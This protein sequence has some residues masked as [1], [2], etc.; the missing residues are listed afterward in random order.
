MWGWTVVWEGGFI[1]A[2]RSFKI[3]LMK[4]SNSCQRQKVFKGKNE[5]KCSLR[6]TDFTAAFTFTGSNHWKQPCSSIK[7]RTV[8]ESIFTE[9]WKCCF[10][11][12]AV[13]LYAQT[14]SHPLLVHLVTLSDIKDL[15]PLMP[16]GRRGQTRGFWQGDEAVPTF[17][18]RTNDKELCWE[19]ELT[20]NKTTTT[21]TTK[22]CFWVF[23]KLVY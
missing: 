10:T 9:M 17:V 5:Q 12:S 7:L 18:N 1:A 23:L 15:F 14:L 20:Q 11:R 2:R 22:T 3:R 21:A 16:A 6:D 19:R 8:S 13:K 4:V